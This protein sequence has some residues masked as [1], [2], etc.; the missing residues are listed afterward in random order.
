VE[1]NGF[2]E[3]KREILYR[4]AKLDERLERMEDEMIKQRMKSGFWGLV[5]GSLPMALA[6]L[7]QLV[8]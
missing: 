2:S 5:G 3:Y 6:V 1:A 7:Y 4:L 8:K